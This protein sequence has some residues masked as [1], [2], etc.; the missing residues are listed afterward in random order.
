M[1]RAEF[2]AVVDAVIAELPEWVVEQ[3]DNLQIVV[4]ERPRPDQTER[5]GNLLGLYEG[6]SLA[7]RS[8]A[9]FGTMP[10]KITIYRQSHLAMRRSEAALKKQIRRTVL[11]EIGHHLGIGDERLHEIGWG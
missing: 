11:H 8:G 1:E 7:D 10:D 3:I 2:E 9:Y 5:F 4:E 6:V